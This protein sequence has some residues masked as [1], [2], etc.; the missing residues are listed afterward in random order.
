MCH[1][2]PNDTPSMWKLYTA[3]GCHAPAH[4]YFK[5]IAFKEQQQNSVTIHFMLKAGKVR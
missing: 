3:T 1:K 2:S 5:C 4:G